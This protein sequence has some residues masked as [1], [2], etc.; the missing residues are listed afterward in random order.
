MT[1]SLLVLR[2]MALYHLLTSASALIVGLVGM[3]RVPPVSGEQRQLLDLVLFQGTARGALGIALSVMLFLFA[4]KLA[5]RFAG[6]DPA[7]LPAGR[8]ADS[9]STEL[10]ILAVRALGVYAIILSIAP[11]SQV[12]ALAWREL[13]G[14]FNGTGGYD[15]LGVSTQFCFTLILGLALLRW[16][17]S[18]GRWVAR[19]D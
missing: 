6:D 8:N 4:P 16:G 15:A 5:T 2:C 13:A 17:R 19:T 11:L 10:L 14:E 7:G 9:G 12:I 3:V 18:I 1:L